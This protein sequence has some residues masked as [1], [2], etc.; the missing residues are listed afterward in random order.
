MKDGKFNRDFLDK[1]WGP[2]DSV[3]IDHPWWENAAMTWLYLGHVGTN[4]KLL[5]EDHE[6]QRVE[7]G[8][9]DMQGIYSDPVRMAPYIFHKPIFFL[10]F[11]I[12]QN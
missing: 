3:F 12:S 5:F 6:K 8:G 2:D 1:V 9:Q 10:H 11:S 7:S 4:E